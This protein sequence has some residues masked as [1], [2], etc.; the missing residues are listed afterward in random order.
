M[1]T[2]LVLFMDDCHFGSVITQ[3]PKKQGIGFHSIDSF[4]YHIPDNPSPPNLIK[5]AIQVNKGE[6]NILTN[7]AK[8]TSIMIYL[9]RI[10][11]V[12][13]ILLNLSIK[14]WNSAFNAQGSSLII[15]VVQLGAENINVWAVEALRKKERQDLTEF[16]TKIGG[17]LSLNPCYAAL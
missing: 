9:C 12:R 13:K 2:F 16:T 14:Y 6:S 3:I 4:L 10:L 7:Y 8:K 1:V 15:V 11:K 5:L 17:K